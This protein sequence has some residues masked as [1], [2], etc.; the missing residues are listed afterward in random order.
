MILATINRWFSVLQKEKYRT[1]RF[2]DLTGLRWG[3]MVLCETAERSS[4]FVKENSGELSALLR[5]LFEF[6]TAYSTGL[7]LFVVHSCVHET[8]TS[9]KR[10]GEKWGGKPQTGSNFIWNPE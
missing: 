9:K 4:A 3:L 2:S 1:L 10:E 6:V 5:F 7:R 8:E